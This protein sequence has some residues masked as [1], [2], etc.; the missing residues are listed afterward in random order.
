VQ[1]PLAQ[2]ASFTDLARWA[3]AEKPKRSRV[4]GVASG[5]MQSA[6]LE[7]ERRGGSGDWE[8]VRPLVFVAAYARLHD[9]VYGIAPAELGPQERKLAACA[10]ARMLKREFDGDAAAMAAFVQW[11]WRREQGR[12]KWRRQ[13][14]RQGFR[15]TWRLLFGGAILTDHRLEQMRATGSH[16]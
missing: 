2:P 16:R 12:E 5:S 7:A 6:L 3:K 15:M 8:G 9:L 13:N 14:G 11:A 1:P 10:A 4:S